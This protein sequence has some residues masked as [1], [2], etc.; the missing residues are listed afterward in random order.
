[1]PYIANDMMAYI[2]NDMMPYIANDMMAV[3][4]YT[5]EKAL[6]KS[7]NSF[8]VNCFPLTNTIGSGI[9]YPPKS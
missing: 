7:L 9:F 1:M 6:Q 8:A 3:V 2:A 4:I 5:I